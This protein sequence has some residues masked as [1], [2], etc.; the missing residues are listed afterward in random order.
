MS[1][2]FWGILA[3]GTGLAA[4]GAV[5]F[6][7]YLDVMYKETI[8]KGPMKRMQEAMD[9]GDMIPLGNM[10]EENMKWVDAQPLEH[11]DM[12]NDRGET[13]KGYLLPAENE[14]KN[15]AVFAH[16]YR[17]SYRGDSANFYKYYH[18]K[19]FNFLSTDHTSAGDSEGSW[20]G[21]DYYESQDMLKWLDYLIERFGEDIK[22]ILHGVSMG[23]ATV[24]QM[25]DK[26]PPQVKLIVADCPFTSARDE[27]ISVA[28]G[29]GVKN[30]APYIFKGM[31]ELNKRLAGYDLNDTDVRDSV[32]NARVPMLFI[33]GGSDD[34]VPTRMGQELFEL[35]SSEKDQL[36]VPD[37]KHA[38]SVVYDTEGYYA[39]LDDF[40]A[41]H[42]K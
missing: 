30:M 40:I 20:V 24:C 5:A 17:G 42:F 23:G 9:Q 13:L 18:D 22:I 12:V 15:F 21:F 26:I 28:N 6:H 37:A 11:I 36:I 25:A 14:S 29:V 2:K 38:D 7:S 33:H 31:N 16:G 3:A 1:K 32:M 27:F 39:K 8:P 19:G 4:V 10:C 35:C 41:K 34:F